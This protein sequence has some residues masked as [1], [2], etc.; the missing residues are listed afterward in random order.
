[1]LLPCERNKPHPAADIVGQASERR[2]RALIVAA[3][4]CN[5]PGVLPALRAA[6]LPYVCIGPSELEAGKAGIVV[7]NREAASEMT[8]HILE[9]G[10]RRIALATDP[11][12]M[13]ER[14]ERLVGYKE[15]MADAQVPIDPRWIVQGKHARAS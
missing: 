8:H 9:L 7:N 10:H 3:P 13:R 4:I 15:A 5:L 11:A 6:H 1:L 2:I 12:Q 14:S